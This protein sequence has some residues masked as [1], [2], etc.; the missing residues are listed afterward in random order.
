VKRTTKVLLLVV[1]TTLLLL[2][3]ASVVY[4]ATPATDPVTVSVTVD[5]YISLS[6]PGDVTLANIVGTGGSSESSATWTV[7]TNN[8][9]GYK[10]ELTT[11]GSPA[12]AKGADT[13]ADLADGGT[14][15]PWSVAAADSAFGFSA[16]G[17][18]TPSALWGD[19]DS[20]SGNYR[21]FQGGSPIEVANN[22]NETAGEDTTVYFKAEVGTSHLQPSGIYSADVTVTATTL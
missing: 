9:N 13:F 4:G 21:G 7:A 22:G 18:S 17:S 3:A 6:N 16:E 10:L 14:P 5:D 12:L 2:A 11:A 15:I 8:D 19:P 1:G 20:G